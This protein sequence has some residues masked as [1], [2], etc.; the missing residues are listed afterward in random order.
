M[1]RGKDSS[2]HSRQN[3]KQEPWAWKWEGAGPSFED[4]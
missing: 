4:R 1:D 2:G 3:G